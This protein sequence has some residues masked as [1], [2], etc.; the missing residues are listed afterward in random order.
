MIHST[1]KK[2]FSIK[3]FFSK[4]DQIRRKLR[5][6][7]HLLKKSLMKNFI[8]LCG[9]NVS[10]HLNISIE[11]IKQKFDIF[12][13]LICTNIN[14]SLKSSLFSSC[15]KITNATPLHKKVRNEFFQCSQKYLKRGLHV[16]TNAYLFIT[17]CQNNN[18]FWFY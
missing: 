9:D 15:L 12:T 16:C 14:S 18:V 5:I 7:S 17:F 3:D 8:F 2:R 4:Y 6:W 13:Y 11:I 10:Q 1:K